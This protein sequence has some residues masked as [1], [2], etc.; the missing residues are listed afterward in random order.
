[1]ISNFGTR[2][3]VE[4]SIAGRRQK[5]RVPQWSIW[6]PLLFYALINDTDLG[7]ECSLSQFAVDTKVSGVVDT[8]EGENANQ[9]N[10]DKL[11]KWPHRNLLR[12]K[13]TK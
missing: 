10:L 3:K 12:F 11:K 8:P 4:H 13:K 6:W 7:I 5:S 1:M 2:G 9:R